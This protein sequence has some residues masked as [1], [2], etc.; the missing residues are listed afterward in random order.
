LALIADGSNA[1]S[2]IE[3]VTD[4]GVPLSAQAADAAG[5][6]AGALAAGALAPGTV[7]D[8]ELPQ[9]AR[10]RLRTVDRPRTESIRRDKASSSW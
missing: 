8:P 2:L 5:A 4:P 9:A 6:L 3:T 1:K 7:V 10:A